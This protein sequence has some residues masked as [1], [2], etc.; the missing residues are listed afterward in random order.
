MDESTVAIVMAA[1]ACVSVLAYTVRYAV[2]ALIS[3]KNDKEN[4]STNTAADVLPSRAT[5]KIAPLERQINTMAA[6]VSTLATQVQ[7]LVDRPSFLT[8]DQQDILRQLYRMHDQLDNDGTPMCY[9]PRSWRELLIEIVQKMRDLSATDDTMMKLIDTISKRLDEITR[10]QNEHD[11][12][13]QQSYNELVS[14]LERAIRDS[15]G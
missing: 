5:I 6:Q 10:Q 1:L 14:R 4:K 9:T 15:R 2:K 13:M 12:A 11:K 7:A 3:T 8:E